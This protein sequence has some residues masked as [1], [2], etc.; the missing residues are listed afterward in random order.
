MEYNNFIQ[1]LTKFNQNSLKS[2]QTIIFFLCKSSQRAA[3]KRKNE[4]WLCR[5]STLRL[6]ISD[7]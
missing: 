4:I 6:Y 3:N 5:Q 1:N 2:Y 7:N